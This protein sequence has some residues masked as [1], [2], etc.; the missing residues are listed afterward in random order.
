MHGDAEWL[1]PGYKNWDAALTEAVRRG[2]Q[3]GH[4]PSDVTKW[5]YGGWHVVDIEHPLAP[6]LPL[7]AA[8][9]HR[10]SAPSA[11][12]AHREAGQRDPR[13][14]AAVH[15]GLE[16]YRRVDGKHRSGRERQ[17]L[18]RVFRD[19]WNDWY[20]G[21][22]FALA[23]HFG[24]CRSK[25]PAHAA[26]SA[27]KMQ[28]TGIRE[29]G[30]AR[31]QS[32]AGAA[33]LVVAA[34]VAS[35]PLYLYNFSCGHD[36]DFHLVS[37]LDALHSWRLGIVYP[38][39][40][41]SPNY[42][43]GEPRFLFYP[44]GT[45]MLGA[46][47]GVVFNWRHVPLLMTFLLLAA[48]GFGT[49]ALARY[50]LSEGPATLAGCFA[51]FSGY[52]LF[53]V[54]ERSAYAELAGGFWI[55]I[56]LLLVLREGNARDSDR[57]LTSAACLRRFG[58]G[59]GGGA[60]GSMVV[61]CASGGDGELSARRCGAHR[62]H[63]FALVDA[64]GAVDCGRGFRTRSRRFL[65]GSGRVGTAVGGYPPGNRRSRRDDPEQLS[66]RS[67]SRSGFWSSTTSNSGRF[68]P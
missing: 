50:A 31:I 60:R 55:P 35:A 2:M 42:G 52:A 11:A 19:Q 7:S 40:A 46:L 10:P 44:P 13:A 34:A 22:T 15:D 38:H 21:T 8:R 53:T 30:S 68:P 9:R 5:A 47:L 39:W 37:W 3:R 26:S 57:N 25:H 49:R 33:I 4:A 51:I 64:G 1:P 41:P 32:L 45:W 65:S 43:A 12:M 67:S 20:N 63:R 61:E 58:T 36:F 54:Y 14:F 24:G 28:G 23:L 18:Q 6:F 62:R 29:Q 17:P 66:L 56:L 16:Q 59:V 27:M 48:T